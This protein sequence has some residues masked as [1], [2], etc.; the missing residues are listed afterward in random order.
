M[1]KSLSEIVIKQP[2]NCQYCNNY[3]CDDVINS[4]WLECPDYILECPNSCGI[5]SQ[6][7]NL[8]KHLESDCPLKVIPCEYNYAGC[9]VLLPRRNM[10]A[11]M[12]E[13][14]AVHLSM[15]SLYQKHQQV[16]EEEIEVKLAQLSIAYD[17]MQHE[18][19]MLRRMDKTD[20]RLNLP[21]VGYILDKFTQRKLNNDKWYSP[22]FYSHNCGYSMFLYVYPN[23]NG[24]SR[25]RH[26]SVYLHV[27]Q[28]AFDEQLTWP[29]RAYVTVQLMDQRKP[30]KHSQHDDQCGK[31]HYTKTLELERI[32]RVKIGNTAGG[33]G[34]R[35]FIPH[36]GLEGRYLMNDCL[37][38]QIPEVKII[39][40]DKDTNKAL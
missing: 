35:N 5:L 2:F 38:F 17:A 22:H 33:V 25:N 9:D 27:M 7:R 18:I 31:E 39:N 26:L 1:E 36:S 14:I 20:M 32:D 3:I 11:H 28:G 24:L 30:G 23:G 13:K 40:S 37:H 34:H 19:T 8:E 29:L 21:P 6:R 10:P 16:K 15:V 12:A 4:H